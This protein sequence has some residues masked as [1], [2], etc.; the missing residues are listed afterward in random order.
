MILFKT[1]AYY[2]GL[3]LGPKKTLVDEYVIA[4][5]IICKMSDF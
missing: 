3:N 2:I 5:S 4:D 1:F